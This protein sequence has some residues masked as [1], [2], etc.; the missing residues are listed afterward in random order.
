MYLDYW[1]LKERPFESA[2]D[3]KFFYTSQSH[4]EA[5]QRLVYCCHEYRGCMVL[6]GEYGCGKTLLSRVLIRELAKDM[7]SQF[8][9]VVNPRLAPKEFLGM[10]WFELGGSEEK[11]GLDKGVLLQQIRQMLENN[12]KANRQTTLIIDEAQ[13]IESEEVLEEIRLLLNIQS[14]NEMLLNIIFIGQPELKEKVL[15]LKP[16]A[17]RIQ[18]WFHL[19][20]LSEEE[21]QKYIEHRLGIAGVTSPIFSPE[22][23]KKIH[24]LTGGI[25]RLINNCCHMALWIGEKSNRTQ[26]DAATVETA[27]QSLKG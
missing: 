16:L 17:Q 15:K 26:V 5:L 19:P 25:P 12:A 23:Y 1:R 21:T 18:M 8:A 9:L 11:G 14:E 27:F 6:T 10:V 13:A 7:R 4:E 2:P 22:A 24:G 3:P 20:P